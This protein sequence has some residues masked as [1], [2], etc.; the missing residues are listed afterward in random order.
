M[1]FFTALFVAIFVVFVLAEWCENSLKRQKNEAWLRFPS[2][3]E[4]IRRT[5][6]S[7][8]IQCWHC[9]SSSI[10]QYGLGARNDQRRIH[11][12]NQCNTNLYRS[13]R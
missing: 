13:T 11:A 12:C 5:K 6:S 10:R 3:E 4:Y 2:V 1:D 9:K 7:G 8:R